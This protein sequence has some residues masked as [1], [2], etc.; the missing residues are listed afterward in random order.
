MSKAQQAKKVESVTAARAAGSGVIVDRGYVPYRG[1]V[2]PQAGRWKV[3]ARRALGM[4]ARS[5]WVIV[6][7]VFAGINMLGFGG[8]M[9]LANK[10]ATVAGAD[11]AQATEAQLSSNAYALYA[12][13]SWFGTLL[14]AF[15]VALFAGGSAVADD[16]RAGA[17]QFYFS[18]PLTRQQYLVGKL[19]AVVSLTA[20]V[21]VG[22]ALLVALFRVTLAPSTTEMWPRLPG[23]LAAIVLGTIIALALAAPALAVS[24][25]SRGRG[26]AQGAFAALFLLPWVVG[27]ILIYSTRS[28]WWG[29]L[30]LPAQLENIGRWLHRVP[31]KPEDYALP[32]WVSLAVVAALVGG[33]L[34]LLRQR[35]ASVEVVAS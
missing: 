5:P 28:A 26:Y 32:V 15:M 20:I 35:L 1:S 33:S 6:M 11:A 23:V 21:S 24:S 13:T 7:L 19:V 4:S 34:A 12:A 22:P 27:K 16:A 29:I 14:L 18:R 8:F 3:I 9:W 25:L 31:A 2:T 30:S 10:I 17:F